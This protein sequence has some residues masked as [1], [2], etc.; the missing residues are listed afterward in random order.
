[1]IYKLCYLIKSETHPEGLRSWFCWSLDHSTCAATSTTWAQTW[2]PQTC[3]PHRS[4]SLKMLSGVSGSSD[5]TDICLSLIFLITQRQALFIIRQTGVLNPEALLPRW[6]HQPKIAG[7]LLGPLL[8]N[9]RKKSYTCSSQYVGALKSVC[10]HFPVMVHCCLMLYCRS[11][12][13]VI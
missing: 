6:C 8:S 1:M 10:S 3:G 4:F 2:R 13:G 11:L 5:P 7:P 12:Y 9:R